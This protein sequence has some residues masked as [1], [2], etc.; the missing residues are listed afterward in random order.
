MADHHS[1]KAALRMMRESEKLVRKFRSAGAGTEVFTVVGAAGTIIEEACALIAN[2]EARTQLMLSL[3]RVLLLSPLLLH[4][5][6]S[7]SDEDTASLSTIADKDLLNA[8]ALGRIK[9]ILEAIP[10][11]SASEPSQD[12]HLA[13]ERK[14][15]PTKN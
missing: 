4:V 11:P 12:F 10:Q 8:T 13:V 15:K 9:A 3:S 14:Y 5:E 7:K 2:N 6:P 1:L